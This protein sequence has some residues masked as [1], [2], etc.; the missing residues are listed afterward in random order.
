M[1]LK[2]ILAR[3]LRSATEQATA[4]YGSEALIISHE[5]VNGRTEVIV[6]VDL[7]PAASSELFEDAPAASRVRSA[8]AADTAAFEDV[9]LSAQQRPA[10]A[11]EPSF[12]EAA[13]PA[14]LTDPGREQIR[15]REIVDLVRQELAVLRKEMRIAQQPALNPL[16]A[17]NPVARLVDRALEADHA[18]MGLR[19]LLSEEFNSIE[20]TQQALSQL[21]EILRSS[22]STRAISAGPLLGRHALFGPSGSGKTSMVLRLAQQAVALFGES[23]VALVSWSDLRPGAWQQVQFGCARLGVECLRVQEAEALADI[24]DGL[25]PKRLVLIDTP[26]H[27]LTEHRQMLTNLCPECA[28]HLVL[29]A[30]VAAHQAERLLRSFPWQSLLLAK[31]DEAHHLWGI[32]QALSHVPSLLNPVAG[33]GPEA[34][35]RADLSVE[36]L[37]QLA[38]DNL[39]RRLDQTENSDKP[40]RMPVNPASQ[41]P[42]WAR[43]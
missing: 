23:Q 28:L 20:T 11:A 38:L 22:L 42:S 39:K 41:T 6:A 21:A 37:V 3:D 7:Q 1:E 29:P 16:H 17:Q 14:G 27:S 25:G 30:D 18:P 13:A 9:L 33:T 32:I 12:G 43:P 4:L 40:A 5:I 24:L 10:S 34:R 31:L 2:R 26:G 35:D 15:A 36:L 19:L 8:S